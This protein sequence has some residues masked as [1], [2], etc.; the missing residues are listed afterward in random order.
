MVAESQL[1]ATNIKEK[2]REAIYYPSV[3]EYLSDF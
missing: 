1:K 3:W 2:R